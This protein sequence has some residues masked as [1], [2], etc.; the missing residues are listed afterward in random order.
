VS[1]HEK[2]DQAEE[3]RRKMIKHSSS[4]PE[5]DILKLPPR[6]STHSSSDK[7][8]KLKFKFPIIKLLAIFFIIILISIV[9]YSFYPKANND[10]ENKNSNNTEEIEFDKSSSEKDL[11]KDKVKTVIKDI[12]KE[13]N[14]P[15]D[16]TT[17]PTV[18]PAK[19]ELPNKPNNETKNINYEIVTHKVSSKD[20]LYSISKKYF[21][22]SNGIKTIMKWNG[23]K[24]EVIKEGQILK[25]PLPVRSSK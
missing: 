5:I 19:V 11:Q 16:E 13:D 15:V 10:T 6:R 21:G 14:D 9:A 24:D 20:T 8:V 25:I 1:E 12:N 7:K 23:L 22:N 17:H 4:K 18:E 2:I 3:L